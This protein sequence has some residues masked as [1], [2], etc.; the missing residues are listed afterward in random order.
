MSTE[1]SILSNASIITI[2][3]ESD[4]GDAF[5]HPVGHQKASNT[6]SSFIPLKIHI[7]LYSDDKDNE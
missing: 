5:R 7:L 1:W 2:L 4:S 3:I 6:Q